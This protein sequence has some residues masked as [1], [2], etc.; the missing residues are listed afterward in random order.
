MWC[1]PRQC[2]CVLNR[3]CQ[4][5]TCSAGE[6]AQPQRLPLGFVWGLDFVCK[7]KSSLAH[8]STLTLKQYMLL[9]WI[10]AHFQSWSELWFG[11][12]MGTCVESKYFNKAASVLSCPGRSWE[13]GHQG[14]ALQ[15]IRFHTNKGSKSLGYIDKIKCVSKGQSIITVFSEVLLGYLYLHH[16]S[17]KP[18]T[19][20]SAPH[21]P[22]PP[23]IK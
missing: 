12:H 8:V 13:L 20:H 6:G 22:M 4:V 19:L 10:S 14:D 15:L 21:R 2:L 3:M 11:K 18:L 5:V 9:G 23:H 1:W 16:L 7:R 17:H